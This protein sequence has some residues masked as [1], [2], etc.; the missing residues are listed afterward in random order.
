MRR[1]IIEQDGD[2]ATN[3][4]LGALVVREVAPQSLGAIMGAL[5]YATEALEPVGRPLPTPVERESVRPPRRR[6]F[7]PRPRSLALRGARG[8]TPA[9]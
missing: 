8:A 3:L 6:Q 5:G 1:I 2:P 9:A 4:G 7:A